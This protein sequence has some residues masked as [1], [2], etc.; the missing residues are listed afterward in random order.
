[1][2]NLPEP[3]D[4]FSLVLRTDFSN[5]PA[6][7]GICRS[8]EAPEG[9]LGLRANVEFISDPAYVGLPPGEV[10]TICPAGVAFLFIV[11]GVAISHPEHPI[12][13]LDLWELPGRS[14]RVIPSEMWGVQN[15]LSIANIGF[16]E[17][18]DAADQDGIFRGFQEA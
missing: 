6:W 9:E 1:M 11:D 4:L 8:I 17:F 12:L 14:F 3:K 10:P 2:N 5:E 13:V 15:N 18:A 16:G 7:E